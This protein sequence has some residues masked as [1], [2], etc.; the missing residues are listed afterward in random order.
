MKPTPTNPL[1]DISLLREQRLWKG[2]H[3]QHCFE[4]HGGVLLGQL[5]EKRKILNHCDD[6]TPDE[7]NYLDALNKT[8]RQAKETLT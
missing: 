7:V 6:L 3:E 1:V 4:V 2:S 8:I 5:I